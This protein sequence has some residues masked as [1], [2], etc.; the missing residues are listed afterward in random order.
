MDEAQSLR[1]F[2]VLCLFAGVFLD[3]LPRTH[4]VAAALQH[5][6]LRVT[7]PAIS[8]A[9]S[10]SAHLSCNSCSALL[11]PPCSNESLNE[12]LKLSAKLQ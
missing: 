7:D 10:G 8:W 1:A 12:S 5:L 4:N 11:C 9:C 3:L 6:Q 2:P